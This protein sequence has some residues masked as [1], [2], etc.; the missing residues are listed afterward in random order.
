[1]NLKSHYNRLYILLSAFLL[2]SSC[3][4]EKLSSQI[5][6]L[7]RERDSLIQTE[8]KLRA[9]IAEMEDRLAVLDTKYPE[10][11]EMVDSLETASLE[12]RTACRYMQ[13]K[14]DSARRSSR[15]KAVLKSRPL[16]IYFYKNYTKVGDSVIDYRADPK[17]TPKG[18]KSTIGYI[19]ISDPNQ[20][21]PYLSFSSISKWKL[22][23]TA[24]LGNQDN[25]RYNYH[26]IAPTYRAAMLNYL[27]LQESDT[28]YIYDLAAD[29]LVR[30][31]LIEA[32]MVARTH[33]SASPPY[34]QQDYEIGLEFIKNPYIISESSS[35][36][37]TYV[38]K[39]NPFRTGAVYKVNWQPSKFDSWPINIQ[40]VT[41]NTLF[42]EQQKNP[43]PSYRFDTPAHTYY[44]IGSLRP[45]QS[46]PSY[47]LLILQDRHTEEIIH[48]Y[49]QSSK[50]KTS[51]KLPF[52]R[53]IIPP[54]QCTQC[55]TGSI[56]K[57]EPVMFYGMHN[58]PEGCPNIY[59][60]DI[61]DEFITIACDNR[62]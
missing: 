52:A 54:D 59:F 2:L 44:I 49:T 11:K 26:E 51:P 4:S 23:D 50:L 39:A 12:L 57:Y 32:R 21:L 24:Y 33:S 25:G 1:M 48:M 55:Y 28:V 19:N 22:I 18:T 56:F 34:T 9:E 27:M 53:K 46:E 42:R 17:G 45:Q 62:Q 10:Q 20:A 37:F 35:L 29:E 31:P 47:W 41:N 8:T 7:S 40:K 43:G 16:T 13:S 60:L 38:G 3:I 6:E 30:Y 14:L 5:T 58:H 61:Q 36:V 15:E